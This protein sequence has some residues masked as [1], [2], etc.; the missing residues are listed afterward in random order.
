MS[1]ILYRL[2]AG[3]A[4]LAVRSG[5]SKDLELIVVRHQLGVLRR[6][7]DRPDLND[8]DRTWK[9]VPK[10]LDKKVPTLILKTQSG[11]FSHHH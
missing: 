5:W 6:Q 8:K 3:L 9:A 11:Q 2:I 10:K 7:I 1:R 4:R